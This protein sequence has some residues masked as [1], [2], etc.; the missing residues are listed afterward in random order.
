MKGHLKLVSFS[1][2]ASQMSGGSR[3]AFTPLLWDERHLAWMGIQLIGEHHTA[4]H[5]RGRGHKM[6]DKSKIQLQSRMCGCVCVHV[7][8][9]D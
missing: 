9:D 7:R 6:S 2:K 4:H 5:T 3:E 1:M 8:V